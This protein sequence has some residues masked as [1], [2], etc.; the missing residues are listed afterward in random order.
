MHS[1]LTI[2]HVLFLKTEVLT[3]MIYPEFLFENDVIGICAP[4]AGVGE[5]LDSFDMSVDVL[6]EI[7]LRTYETESVRNEGCPSAPAEVRGYEFNSLFADDDIKAVMSAA[8]GDYNIEMLPYIDQKLVK[9]HPKLFAGYSDP[10][11]IE[12]LL[13]T[14]LDIATVYGVNAGA[15]DWRPLHQFHVNALEILTGNI[16]DQ[17][18]YDCWASGGYNEETG[19]YDMDAPV[20]WTVLRPEGGEFCEDG[21][22]DVTGRLIGGCI[23]VI[24]WMIGTPYEDLQGFCSRYAD[25]GFIWFFDTFELNPMQL[26]YSMNKMK[27]MGLFDNARA[28]VFGRVCF[29]G[30][31]DDIDYLEQLERVFGD[32][33]VPVIWGADIGHTKPSMTV[34][35]GS[36]GHLVCEDGRAWLSMELR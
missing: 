32:T 8:G 36:V 4:S 13:T 28:V 21:Y 7:G 24:D 26:M 18:S 6:H 30:E 19:E 33:D 29:P 27:M 15:W 34:I 23:D 11:S 16:V 2:I 10:T 31:A 9:S 5:K 3:Y 35:N 25:D 1:V 14:R 20:E 12:M 17:E 22:L